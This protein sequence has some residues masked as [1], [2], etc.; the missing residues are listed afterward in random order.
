MPLFFH[1]SV[2][3]SIKEP[4]PWKPDVQKGVERLELTGSL[5]SLLQLPKWINDM[6][7]RSQGREEE[8]PSSSQPGMK[9]P[10]FQ[11]SSGSVLLNSLHPSPKRQRTHRS[12][13]SENVSA[14][15]YI[16]LRLL[17][18]HLHGAWRYLL[19]TT[20]NQDLLN[21]NQMLWESENQLEFDWGL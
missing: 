20:W 4:I 17:V 16:L 8:R 19:V 9:R 5:S 13:S 15:E 7:T 10:L 18:P 12:S 6:S 2:S 21:T 3:G 11:D 14:S 1:C